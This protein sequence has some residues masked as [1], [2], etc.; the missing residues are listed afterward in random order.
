MINECPALIERVAAQRSNSGANTILVKEFNGGIL[1]IVGSN[2]ASGLRSMPV[3]YLFLD[4]VD[5]YPPF[6]GKGMDPVEE[7][8]KRTSTFEHRS[9]VFMSST[10]T[11]KH[12]S[13]IEEQFETTNK[14]YYYVPCPRCGHKQ[15]L[16]W[17][18]VRWEK[19]RFDTVHYVCEDCG[20]KFYEHEKPVFLAQG[21]WR[22]TSTSVDAFT[23][24]FHLSSLYSPYGWLSWQTCAKEWEAAAGSPEKQRSFRTEVLGL[25]W[26]ETQNTPNWR[27]LYDRRED[28][29]IGTVPEG[30]LVLSGGADIQRDRIEV[31]VWGWAPDFECWLVDHIVLP[32]NPSVTGP[33]SVWDDLTALLGRVWVN[34]HGEV[35]QLHNLGVDTGDG[36]VTLEAFA[37]ARS[38]RPLPVMCLK[39]YDRWDREAPV[40]GPKRIDVGR[41]GKKML[42]GVESW[43]V[44]VSIFKAQ[45]YARLAMER[46]T[47]EE[48]AAGGR[49]P[50]GY[51]HL[52]KG[53]S[54][55]LVQQLVSEEC[56]SVKMKTG[57]IRKEWRK[58]QE[59]NEFLDC[60]IYA[61][62]AMHEAD[63]YGEVFWD[64]VRGTKSAAKETP[65]VPVETAPAPKS[66]VP[67]VSSRWV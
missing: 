1:V 10:P 19:G 24:G 31:S 6:V 56:V 58:T 62:A 50:P 16:V 30:V 65:K 11:L 41:N 64:R 9:K 46:P 3:R 5:V 43:T 38:V 21:E 15:Q 34:E 49:F 61:R 45:L 37:W 35:F 17:E 26:E 28:W 36:N 12:I 47:E 7:V 33:G 53:C 66:W 14:Q 2:S 20:G 42:R 29:Q 40:S 39:G 23:V 57:R 27:R 52:P 67:R 13:R 22:A 18:N 54:A 44:S 51:V 63:V 25:T 32:G 48:L 8:I 60:F 59:R 4:E 55:D